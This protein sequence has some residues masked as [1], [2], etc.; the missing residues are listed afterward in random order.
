[1][2]STKQAE[3][4]ELDEINK[5][6]IDLGFSSFSHLMKSI[7]SP[8][9]SGSGPMKTSKRSH[10]GHL[11]PPPYLLYD[12]KITR[13]TRTRLSQQEKQDKFNQFINDDDNNGPNN[14]VSATIISKLLK[15]K[16]DPRLIVFT[17]QNPI[18]FSKKIYKTKLLPI[19]KQKQKQQLQLQRYET[20]LQAVHRIIPPGQDNLIQIIY[21][22]NF[23]KDKV[24]GILYSELQ[25]DAK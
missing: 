22:Y 8:S 3:L 25:K 1:M 5:M 6:A 12:R 13:S 15:K 20:L 18:D 10:R 9:S 7:D 4:A 14:D 24:E 2:K 21:Q 17:V 16:K 19:P 23:W 11:V